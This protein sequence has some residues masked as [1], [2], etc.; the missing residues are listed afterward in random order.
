M[1]VITIRPN[2]LEFIRGIFIVDLYKLMI[3]LPFSPF[4]VKFG[5]GHKRQNFAAAA[6]DFVKSLSG[7]SGDHR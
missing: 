3:T 5:L 7:L 6:R 2:K 4:T 1:Y